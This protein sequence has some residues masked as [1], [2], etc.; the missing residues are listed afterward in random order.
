MLNLFFRNDEKLPFNTDDA[1][2]IYNDGGHCVATKFYRSPFAHI[3]HNNERT[4]IDIAFDSLYAEAMKKGLRDGK[5]EKPL[6]ELIKSEIVLLFPDYPDLDDFIADKIRR[7][8]R[9]L[10]VRKKRFRRKANLN[11]WNYFVTLT[12]DDKKQTAE[13]FRAKLRKCLSNLHT[14]RGWRYMGVFETAPSTGRLHFHGLLYVPDYEM[15]GKLNERRD[16]STAQGKMQITHINDF[17][18]ERFG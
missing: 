9:N 4:D 6:T 11:K 2:K 16:Y 3:G 15:V 5:S 1:Y 7:K 17:F 12:Y 14:R 10:A 8:R 18:A 13:T